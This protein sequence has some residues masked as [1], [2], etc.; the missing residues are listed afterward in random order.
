MS[1]NLQRDLVLMERY[2][3]D[4]GGIRCQETFISRFDVDSS[5]EGTDYFLELMPWG[6]RTRGVRLFVTRSVYQRAARMKAPVTVCTKPGKFGFEW[7][8][9]YRFP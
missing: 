6:E 5:S 3:G 7:L 8:V 4:A 2:R 9:S 1:F